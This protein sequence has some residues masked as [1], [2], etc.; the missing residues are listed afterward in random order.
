MSHHRDGVNRFAIRRVECTVTA[1]STV[2][3]LKAQR[4][5]DVYCLSPSCVLTTFDKQT[6]ITTPFHPT[7]TICPCHPKVNASAD[8]GDPVQGRKLTAK[9]VRYPVPPASG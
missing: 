1:P 5:V 3:Q 4:L 6:L 2:E 8:L 9:F 7:G